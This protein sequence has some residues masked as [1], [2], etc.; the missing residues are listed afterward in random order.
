VTTVLLVRHGATDWNLERRAQ[1][2]ADIPLNA[3]G[4]EQ[5]EA[6]ARELAA[7]P[8]EAVYTSDLARAAD[9]ARAIARA[10]GLEPAPDP[11]LREIDQG[12][13]TGRTGDE[14]RSRWPHLWDDTRRREP[15]RP[16]GE[17]P[18]QLRERALAA[19]TRVVH[20]HPTGTVVLVSHGVTMRVLV[21]E[22]L[23]FDEH[24]SAVLRGVS[25]GGVV[26]F[27]ANL[28]GGRLRF[29]GFERLDGRAPALDD[30]NR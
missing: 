1:G 26:R 2:Q 8:I 6:T 27:E 18:E 23:G 29:G 24:S 15:A 20:E 21:A 17:T 4:R 28:D 25:N 12:E 13:W 14:I 10:H 30:P 22:V 9:T 7:W 19:L 3:L 16:G 11:R 5:A